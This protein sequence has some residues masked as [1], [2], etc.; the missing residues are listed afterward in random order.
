M[1]IDIVIEQTEKI[2]DQVRADPAVM[3]AAARIYCPV[4]VAPKQDAFGAMVVGIDIDVESRDYGLV[5]GLEDSLKPGYVLMGYRLA[6]RSGAKIGDEIAVVGQGIDGSL[7]ND[8]YTIQDIIR[9]PAD[10]INQSGIVMSLEDAQQLLAL[11]DQS[12][13]LVIRTKQ[14]GQVIELVTQHRAADLPSPGRADGW[15]V[16]HE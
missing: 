15:G 14:S 13:E 4:L 2:L 9:S 5:S 11:S 7:A 1:A 3:N 16:D 12:Y 8:L 10:L 6:R